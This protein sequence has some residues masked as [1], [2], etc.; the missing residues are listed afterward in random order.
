MA[1]ICATSER[2]YAV[3]TV[4][5]H[6]VDDLGNSGKDDQRLLR[7]IIR[8]YHRLADNPKAREALKQM[9]PESLKDPDKKKIT[10]EAVRRWHL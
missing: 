5:S 2:F 3:C 8:C 7:H 1:Y 6:M 4:L 10:D 9:L